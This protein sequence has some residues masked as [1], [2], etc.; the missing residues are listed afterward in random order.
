MSY[1]GTD[2]QHERRGAASMLINWGLERG[3]SEGVPV[4]LESTKNAWP[5]YEK[6][7]FQ[8]EKRILMIL[9]GVEEGAEVL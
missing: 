6:L 2:P 5:L 1:I 7:E 3:K 4:A 9:R 8:S